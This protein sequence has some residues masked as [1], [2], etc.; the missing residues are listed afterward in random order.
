MSGKPF[1]DLKKRVFRTPSEVEPKVENYHPAFSFGRGL[2]ESFSAR[3]WKPA[4]PVAAQG[5]HILHDGALAHGLRSRCIDDPW[6]TLCNVGHS[7]VIESLPA[8]KKR[9]LHNSTWPSSEVAYQMISTFWVGLRNEVEYSI[10]YDVTE[11]FGFLLL[12]YQARR[13]VRHGLAW[14]AIPCNTWVFMNFACIC[15]RQALVSWCIVHTMS[16]MCVEIRSRG[17]TKRSHFRVRGDTKFRSVRQGN[18]LA[19]RISYMLHYNFRKGVSYVLENP[20]SS[21]LWKYKCIQKR[22]RQH[23]AHRVVVHLGAYGSY[24]SKPVLCSAHLVRALIKHVIVH[25][26]RPCCNTSHS[27]ATRSFSMGQHPSWLS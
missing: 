19:R 1:F 20:L 18:R 21:L 25:P 17:S 4:H 3:N 27:S 2:G 24:T 12:L 5:Q 10:K 15:E 7:M 9:L 14:Y 6:L 13:L 11:A 22:L 23:N 16:H 26:T 8:K